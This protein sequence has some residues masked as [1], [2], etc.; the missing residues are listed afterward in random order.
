MRLPFLSGAAPLG[1]DGAVRI[2]DL[3]AASAWAE[4]LWFSALLGASGD[5]TAG[6]R[7]LLADLE[8][9][10]RSDRVL[11][12]PASGRGR[13]LLSVT[14]L[15][16]SE[17]F[18]ALRSTGEP[19]NSLRP[20]DEA[21]DRRDMMSVALRIKDMLQHYVSISFSRRETR[22]GEWITQVMTAT[23]ATASPATPIAAA[24]DRGCCS[25]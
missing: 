22:I 13:E 16:P 17:P 18:G 5:K 25:N 1:W 6:A 12:G 2:G 14:G 8:R 7:I 23:P 4:L 15:G 20:V 9:L 19:K 21:A 3:R 24:D 11:P 10:G